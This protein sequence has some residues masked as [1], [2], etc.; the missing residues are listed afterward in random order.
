MLIF[1]LYGYFFLQYLKKLSPSCMVNHRNNEMMTADEMFAMNN[2]KLRT[3]AKD[4]LKRTAE[5]CT[6]VIVLIATVAFAAAY[7]I[8]GGPNQ[9]TGF[10][11][12]LGRPFFLVFTVTDVL[13]L[14]FALTAVVIFLAILTSSF[15]LKDF[16]RSLPQKLLLGF[17]LLFLSVSMMMVAFAATVILMIHNRERWTK[18]A[19]YVV[20]FFPV[21][22]F[23]LS[24]IPLYVQLAEIFKYW[25]KKIGSSL[26]R[27]Q[28]ATKLAR[29]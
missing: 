13:S 2:E 9:E 5:H 7:T 17:T 20:A 15:E 10:P 27:S 8:P 3:E 26:P 25:V 14:G 11:L 19:V 21:C 24:Y 4:W 28:C 23:V 1:V 18:I 6:V 29:V 16:T 22:I 12:L